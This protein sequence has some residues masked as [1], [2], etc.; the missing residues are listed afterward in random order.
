MDYRTPA[1]VTL[2]PEQWIQMGMTLGLTADQL[3]QA[4]L[5]FSPENTESP[6]GSVFTLDVDYAKTKLAMIKAGHYDFVNDF[7]RDNDPV[8]GRID[9]FGTVQA[10]LEL[11]HFNRIIS[12][13]DA[14]KEIKK[15][16]LIPA[17]V[18]HLLAL[19]AKHSNLQKEFP[20]VA[21]GS[22]WQNSDG[23]RSVPYLWGSSDGDRYLRLY[24]IADV[25]SGD[26][27]FLAVRK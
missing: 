22:V 21:L 7:L 13:A 12:T 2:S 24:W 19:G 27:R 4:L 17:G 16:G 10:A 25:W 8:K 3:K 1:N 5:S 14:L 23:G 26:Y 18:E 15:R 11:V 20:I 6:Q 9:G